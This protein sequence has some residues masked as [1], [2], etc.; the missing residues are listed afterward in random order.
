MSAPSC[1]RPSISSTEFASG[2]RFR[3]LQAPE[4]KSLRIDCFF[5]RAPREVVGRRVIRADRAGGRPGTMALRELAAHEVACE[6]PQTSPRFRLENIN[7]HG[8]TFPRL[9]MGDRRVAGGSALEVGAHQIVRALAAARINLGR[10]RADQIPIRIERA[11]QPRLVGLHVGLNSLQRVLGDEEC[12]LHRTVV[13]PKTHRAPRRIECAALVGKA[14]RHRRPFAAVDAG[15]RSRYW[16]R[17]R[18]TAVAPK[19]AAAAKPRLNRVIHMSRSSCLQAGARLVS[20]PPAP[21]LFLCYGR[22][23]SRGCALFARLS[24]GA[25]PTPA[26]TLG[27]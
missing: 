8:L 18:M 5:D 12:D 16:L 22:W 23:W 21:G 3:F 2:L 15:V 11:Q 27:G 13:S 14:Q 9:T 6:G 25:R 10:P 26:M 24:R 19:Q 20:L 4:L 17:A 7:S 1:L